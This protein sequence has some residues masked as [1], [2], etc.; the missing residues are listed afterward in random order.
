[1]CPSSNPPVTDR[2]PWASLPHRCP[3][4][5]FQHR[6]ASSSFTQ[7][8]LCEGRKG[9]CIEGPGSG[10]PEML[11]LYEGND[12]HICCH[13]QRHKREGDERYEE[14]ETQRERRAMYTVEGRAHV[15]YT[16]I[17]GTY[18]MLAFSPPWWYSGSQ[19]GALV[20]PASVLLIVLL[21]RFA[22]LLTLL[23]FLRPSLP[24]HLPSSLYTGA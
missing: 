16:Y 18:Q 1:M 7:H 21:L 20:S 11:P 14:R 15:S 12:P 22:A 4:T 9:P 13:A 6:E 10:Q 19:E 3:L 17:Q 23:R 8:S 5:S 2:R 24:P